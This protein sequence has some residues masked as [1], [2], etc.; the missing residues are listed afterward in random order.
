MKGKMLLALL[1]SAGGV[2]ATYHLTAGPPALE[3]LLA[4]PETGRTLGYPDVEVIVP[5][6]ELADS[7][8]P[9]RITVLAFVSESCP[10]C[11]QLHEHLNGL[12][13]LRPD[14]AVRFV[15]LGKRWGGVDYKQIY[16]V[17]IRSIPHV[18]IYGPEGKLLEA[19][20]GRDKAGLELLY[21]WINSEFR[22]Q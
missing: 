7:C 13:R 5:S 10:A 16:G 4:E 21:R 18:L 2:G 9:G 14:V 11:L 17:N 20:D 12:V 15:D 1:L 19:D 3:R 22:R 6:K 8:E